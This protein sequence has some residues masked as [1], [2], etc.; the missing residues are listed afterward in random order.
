ME[1]WLAGVFLVR[2]GSS[3]Q[4]NVLDMGMVEETSGDGFFDI[5]PCMAPSML[6][7]I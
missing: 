6:R 4:A 2:V 7:V 5:G 1:Q 3:S